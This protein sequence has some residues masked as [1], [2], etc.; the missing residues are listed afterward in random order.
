MVLAVALPFH[1]RYF[2]G[3]LEIM[4]LEGWGQLGLFLFLI[5]KVEGFT[6][7]DAYLK[8]R[9]LDEAST[10]YHSKAAED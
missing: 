6:G 8:L 4:S 5:R 10:L 2:G 7:S 9:C 3:S 1:D